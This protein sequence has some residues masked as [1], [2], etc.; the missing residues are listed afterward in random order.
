MATRRHA[1]EL[2]RWLDDKLGTLE[3][4]GD[5]LCGVV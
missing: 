4:P 5:G 3:V 2:A 1:E